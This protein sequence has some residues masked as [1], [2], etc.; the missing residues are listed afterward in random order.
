MS[1]MIEAGVRANIR[2][3]F[4][5]SDAESL[6]F[7][8]RSMLRGVGDGEVLLDSNLRIHGEADCLQQL[9]MTSK[10][11]EGRPFVEVLHKSDHEHFKD[12]LALASSQ[13][14]VAAKGH[15]PPCLRVSL[16][17]AVDTWVHADIYHVP[18]AKLPGRRDG[19]VKASALPHGI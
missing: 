9:L 18:I 5:C 16:L 13:E 1:A 11:L 6:M 3:Q 4:N 12:F 8:F 2:A 7:S 17:H 10:K 15:V 14:K 19:F